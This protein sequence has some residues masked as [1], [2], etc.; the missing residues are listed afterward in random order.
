MNIRWFWP[1]LG[2]PTLRNAIWASL[3]SDQGGH[4]RMID[5]F[6]RFNWFVVFSW[7]LTLLMD[8]DEL[9][10]DLNGF[11]WFVDMDGYWW[12][13]DGCQWFFIYSRT[14]FYSDGFWRSLMDLGFSYLW[15]LHAI[16]CVLSH[17]G[18]LGSVGDGSKLASSMDYWYGSLDH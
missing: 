8:I 2:P 12:I 17:L 1:F 13:V 10:T 3:R 4:L 9:L 16:S 5:R 7:I 14:V 18:Y 15:A 11:W 6:G